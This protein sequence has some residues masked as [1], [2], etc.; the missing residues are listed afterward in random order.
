M[1][2]RTKYPKRATSRSPGPSPLSHNQTGSGMLPP[3]Q[4]A[5]RKAKSSST[6]L[7][8]RSEGGRS[9]ARESTPE[10]PNSGASGFGGA[11]DDVQER[12]PTLFLRTPSQSPQK[13]RT[14]GPPTGLTPPPTQTRFEDFGEDRALIHGGAPLAGAVFAE[15]EDVFTSEQVSGVFAHSL[16]KSNAPATLKSDESGTYNNQPP[17]D[18]PKTRLSGAHLSISEHSSECESVTHFDSPQGEEGHLTDN[19]WTTMGEE[20]KPTFDKFGEFFSASH[21][22]PS[23]AG[24]DEASVS[25]YAP[26]LQ[27]VPP[28]EYNEDFSSVYPPV[29][30]S[31]FQQ[32]NL[33]E[34]TA[35]PPWNGRRDFNPIRS[36]SPNSVTHTSRARYRGSRHDLDI[37]GE[38]AIEDSDSLTGFVTP[39]GY[40]S[41]TS[42]FWEHF[43]TSQDDDGPAFV[44][45]PNDAPES[46]DAEYARD[47][48]LQEYQRGR[49][50]TEQAFKSHEY[51]IGHSSRTSTSSLSFDSF[52]REVQPGLS[53]PQRK[54][55]LQ[56]RE[57]VSMRQEFSSGTRA[58][59]RLYNGFASDYSSI[60]ASSTSELSQP[61]AGPSSLHPQ[62]TPS[63]PQWQDEAAERAQ[64]Q[65]YDAAFNDKY[66]GDGAYR[67][68]HHDEHQDGPRDAASEGNDG[69][70]GGYEQAAGQGES[71]EDKG[72]GKDQALPNSKLA[73]FEPVAFSPHAKATGKKNQHGNNRNRAVTSPT[74]RAWK[75]T[76][77]SGGPAPSTPSALEFILPG[78]G[79]TLQC[80]WKNDNG[81]P[82]RERMNASVEGIQHHLESRHDVKNRRPGEK[83]K[84]GY[85]RCRTYYVHRDQFGAHVY[86]KHSEYRWT[87]A[88]AIRQ[89]AHGASSR[90]ATAPSSGEAPATHHQEEC[91]KGQHHLQRAAQQRQGEQ[92]RQGG[93]VTGS[94]SDFTAVHRD[95]Q[96]ERNQGGDEVED[97]GVGK[98][99]KRR[100]SV[101]KYPSSE[102]K[103][104]RKNS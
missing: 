21:V 17:A 18:Q 91:N 50:S 66:T 13:A 86:T 75:A 2:V 59:T 100:G 16:T 84:C 33:V 65:E 11:I 14:C 54:S 74:K 32:A 49:P 67:S 41:D 29:Q 9:T 25:S 56:W 77:Q 48:Q 8:S 88:I 7:A 82:C 4:P 44:A 89:V 53:P 23:F 42:S 98:K 62:T 46:W 99:R 60:A 94:F 28:F 97:G 90:S 80:G 70:Q 24:E 12:G 95:Q 34:R 78:N 72:K 96:R 36:M 71:R 61:E 76:L 38:S 6:M 68:Q 103:S 47:A 1:L 57:A 58:M 5:R 3:K 93:P 27:P 87:S 19:L 52:P 83:L 39:S 10:A 31:T 63:V 45:S 104:G 30:H 26:S 37:F 92:G 51:G 81:M 20:L 22:N 79:S 85:D 55:L 35:S 43:Q 69:N 101:G 15:W 40:S 102:E 73:S 64:Q